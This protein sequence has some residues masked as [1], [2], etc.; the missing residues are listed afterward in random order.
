M[1]SDVN[2]I[3]KWC[4]PLW[5]KLHFNILKQNRKS[6]FQ[7]GKCISLFIDTTDTSSSRL[8][9]RVNIY[10]PASVIVWGGA[11]VSSGMGSL[12]IQKGRIY[13]ERYIK[14]LKQ[15]MISFSPFHRRNWIF[16]AKPRTAY[17]RK[18][19]FYE[20]PN[21]ALPCQHSRHFTE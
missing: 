11:L 16:S 4:H 10:N 9:R 20:S 6:R 7:F 5:S 8:K 3:Q 13:A 17:N 1:M 15:L 19:W 12:H 18:A 14:L 21:A 2:M